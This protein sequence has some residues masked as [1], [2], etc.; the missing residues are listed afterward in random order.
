MKCQK[1]WFQAFAFTC[2]LCRSALGYDDYCCTV[3]EDVMGM[4]NHKMGPA[5]TMYTV[6]W[7]YLEIALGFNYDV[8]LQDCDVLWT[9]NPVEDFRSDPEVGGCTRDNP[10]RPIV[11]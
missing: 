3:A 10:V 5:D 11:A 1:A 9:K 8:I 6:R 7:Q 4:D 2:K